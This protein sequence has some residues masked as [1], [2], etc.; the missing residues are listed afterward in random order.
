MKSKSLHPVKLASALIGTLMLAMASQTSAGL[1]GVSS[2]EIQHDFVA[3]AD[4][5][6]QVAEVNAFATGSGTDVA[7]LLAGAT[8]MHTGVGFSGFADQAINGN[9]FGQCVGFNC[10]GM[11]GIFHSDTNSMG[12]MLTI[13]LAAPT[14]LDSLE[15]F[16]RV[17]CCSQRDFYVIDL[18]DASGA[19]LQTVNLNASG[20]RTHTDSIVLND[21][22][23][24]PQV[25]ICGGNPVP[26]PG[27]VLLLGLGLAGLG[28]SRKKKA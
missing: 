4:G 16:G 27:T 17:D 3:S 19:V 8:T 20:L 24:N 11:A 28:L 22:S 15:I 25:D 5:W 10:S 23:C 1:V 7:S 9:N 18:L 21:T 2:I 13:I 12:E 6:L 26:T 14:E